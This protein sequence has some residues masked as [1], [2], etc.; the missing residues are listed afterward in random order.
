MRRNDF[1]QESLMKKKLHT[2]VHAYG[3]CKDLHVGTR[4]GCVYLSSSIISSGEE[5]DSVTFRAQNS[6]QTT[7]GA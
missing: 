2:G 6:A 5:G 3:V 1:I 7:A 4:R